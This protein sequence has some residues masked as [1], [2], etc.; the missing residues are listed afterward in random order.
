MSDSWRSHASPL[1]PSNI[2]NIF[3]NVIATPSSKNS[4]KIPPVL[5]SACP[6]FVLN[7][8]S[9]QLSC[10]QRNN[11]HN[12]KNHYTNHNHSPNPNQNVHQLSLQTIAITTTNNSFIG[13]STDVVNVNSCTDLI[14]QHAMHYHYQ[15]RNQQLC[16]RD[17][18]Q[19]ASQFQ[20]HQQQ[21]ISPQTNI[22]VNN[23]NLNVNNRYTTNAQNNATM[24]QSSLTISSPTGASSTTL[25][26]NQLY[27]STIKSNLIQ[28]KK[29]SA[30][31]IVS[32]TSSPTLS[33]SALNL[34][35]PPFFMAETS[36]LSTKTK[37]K[38]KNYNF[39]YTQ[40]VNSSNRSQ[41]LIIQSHHRGGGYSDG[42]GA[43]STHNNGSMNINEQMHIN[44]GMTQRHG[45]HGINSD[46]QY[47]HRRHNSMMNLNVSNSSAA[48]NTN[49]SSGQFDRHNH[50]VVS[51]T[52]LKSCP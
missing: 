7:S 16:H 40:I 48:N 6:C 13:N 19:I 35:S 8:H 38:S 18:Q 30:S 33:S 51:T 31:T 47:H 27:N 22:N 49:N 41:Q 28:R 3:I 5:S 36:L 14:P 34:P 4:T 17:L 21:P 12:H 9:F 23:I 20:Q 52:F 42:N 15:Q 1:A 37:T 29:N 10:Y 39:V 26:T 2:S 25:A 50:N 45:G 24:Y 11:H 32:A 43:G 44:N 46:H